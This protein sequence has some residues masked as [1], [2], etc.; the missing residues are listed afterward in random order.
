MRDF[1]KNTIILLCIGLLLQG[2][3]AKTK[4]EEFSREDVDLSYITKIAVLPFENHTKDEFAAQRM[5]DI[6]ITQVLAMGL[7]DVVD[8]GVVDSALMDFAVE[9]GK[10]IDSPILKRL[11]KRLGV[12][13]FLMGEVNEVGEDRRGSMSFPLVSLTMRLV[14]SKAVLVLWRASGHKSGY[15]TMYRLFG[16]SPKDSFEV[17]MELVRDMLLTIPVSGVKGGMESGGEMPEAGPVVEQGGD[18]AT[19]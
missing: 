1:V 9:P 18:N 2:C 17:S 3:A 16:I 8:K 12:D 14:D 13:A 15:S 11:G 19:Q 4:I 6:T 10:P 7:F 5:R